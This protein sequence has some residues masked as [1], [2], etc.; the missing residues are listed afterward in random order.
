M[1]GK[2]CIVAGV[3]LMVTGFAGWVEARQ[4]TDVDGR[5]MEADFVSVDGDKVVIRK[6]GREHSVALSRLSAGDRDWIDRQAEPAGNG[7]PVGD[8][9]PTGLIK[10]HP[11]TVLYRETPKEWAD[12]RLARKV[13]ADEKFSTPVQD[14]H[15][16]GFEACVCLLYTSDAADEYQRV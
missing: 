8:A 2:T 5:V 15:A 12:G 6:N 16:S 1:S 11:V 14:A 4:W 13:S 7:T 3:A 9:A 10:N